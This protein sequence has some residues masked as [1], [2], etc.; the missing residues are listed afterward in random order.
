MHDDDGDEIGEYSIPMRL[1]DYG[2]ID[3]LVAEAHQKMIDVL[4]QW[5]YV[6]EMMRKAYAHEEDDQ[7]RD[8][9]TPE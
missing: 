1:A 3:Q 5:I 6:T 4:R 8:S 9:Q 2:G 7:N